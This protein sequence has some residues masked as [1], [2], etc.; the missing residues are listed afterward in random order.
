MCCNRN[1]WK[2]FAYTERRL[3][4]VSEAPCK[5]IDAS[6][7]VVRDPNSPCTWNLLINQA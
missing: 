1:G 3:R 2:Y 4:L 6:G 7:C 5:E